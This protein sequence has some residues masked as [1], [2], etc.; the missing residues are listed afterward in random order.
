MWSNFRRAVP[1][2]GVPAAELE[3]RVQARLPLDGM[4]AGGT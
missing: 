2:D 3:R 1:E 4:R